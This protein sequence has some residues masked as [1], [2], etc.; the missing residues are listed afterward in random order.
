MSTHSIGGQDTT[1]IQEA[2]IIDHLEK[3]RDR[4]LEEVEK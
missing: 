1:H 3:K 4:A 2:S